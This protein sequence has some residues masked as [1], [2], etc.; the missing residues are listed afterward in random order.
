MEDTEFDIVGYTNLNEKKL[1]YQENKAQCTEES[2]QE[3]K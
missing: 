3:V 1:E 2:T